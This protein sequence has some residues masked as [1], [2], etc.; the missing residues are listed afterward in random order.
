VIGAGSGTVIA[1]G[2]G[3]VI[4]TGSGKVILRRAQET[5]WPACTFDTVQKTRG[6][7][8]MLSSLSSEARKEKR[9]VSG[10]G[11]SMHRLQEMVR[12]HRLGGGTAHEI[13]ASLKMSPNTERRYRNALTAAGLLVGSADELP[14]LEDLKAVIDKELPSIEP[15]H[16]QSSI[17]RW[18]PQVKEL[19]DNGLT[20]KAIHDRLR[21]K[22]KG[23][24]EGK[25]GA[26]KRMV[27]RL[28]LERGVSAKDIAIPVETEPGHTAQV[29]FGYAGYRRDPKTGRQ[30]KAW[31]FVMVLSY[32]RHQYVEYV[33]DQKVETWVRLHI[34]AFKALGGVPAD[35]VPD[36]LK[37]AVLK[38]AFSSS[39][40]TTLNRSYRELARHYRFKIAPTP[41]HAPKKKGKVESGVKYVNGN[42][43]KGR[44]GEDITLSNAEASRWVREIA[45]V[46]THGSTGRAPLEVFEQEE[47]GALLPLP[48]EPYRII[49][50]HKATVHQDSHF[51]F[52]GR[53]YSVHWR[54]V[55]AQGA[56]P[57]VVWARATATT[58]SAYIDDVRVA[59]H[60]RL[61]PGLRS[62]KEEHLP[63]H[64][65]DYRHRDEKY[66]RER[67]EQLAP[68]VRAFID[69]VLDHDPVRSRVDIACSCMRLLES[70]P[71]ERA[72]TV[73]RH[74]L[75]FGNVHYRELKR[76]VEHR[77]DES[78]AASA[79]SLASNAWS[80]P[81]P[82]FARTGEEYR[83]RVNLRSAA[84][85]DI[86]R[87]DATPHGAINVWKVGHG[88]A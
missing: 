33:F 43:G 38:A 23:E 24:Y 44:N 83:E 39:E 86:Q 13:A 66:W 88:I 78:Q 59:D 69:T 63:E 22:H 35:I 30:R 72:I 75:A 17:A 82:V 58:V 70:L 31:V 64:R 62:T 51:H 84:A 37:A 4:L 36:N 45:G 57:T 60:D 77:L 65:R 40:D 15:A 26:V 29:D 41:P 76:I 2:S 1:A 80:D 8:S 34:N 50:W 19:L 20:P 7:M 61:G 42:F 73:T 28:R 71:I 87:T 11:I 54:H 49:L 6:R 67:A 46:R 10:Q 48:T 74:A 9:S 52:D 68:E 5:D 21:L 12:L 18:K 47:R 81:S 25:L 55:A 32:S 16:E 79:P 3:K 53:L 85:S 14:P 56:K 27:K